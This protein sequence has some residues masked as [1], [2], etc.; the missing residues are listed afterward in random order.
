METKVKKPHI[1]MPKC[2]MERF[3]D[4]NKSI[5]GKKQPQTVFVFNLAD[6]NITKECIG[7]LELAKRDITSKI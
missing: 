6:N 1:Q 4:R 7:L 5:D 2:I 3:A